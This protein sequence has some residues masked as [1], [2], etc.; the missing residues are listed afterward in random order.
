[1]SWHELFEIS[2]EKTGTKM[3]LYSKMVPRNEVIESNDH[4][5]RQ[6]KSRRSKARR[7]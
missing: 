5:G 4:N 1:M 7:D 3:T 2:H 6:R